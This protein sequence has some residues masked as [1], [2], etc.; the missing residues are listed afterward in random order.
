[1]Y[2]GPVRRRKICGTVACSPRVSAL[3]LTRLSPFNRI[4]HTHSI[5]SL[6][7]SPSLHEKLSLS[8]LYSSPDCQVTPYSVAFA[9]FALSASFVSI[10]EFVSS[11]AGWS[12]RWA[13]HLYSLPSLRRLQLIS[14]QCEHCLSRL[15]LTSP[16]FLL[17]LPNILG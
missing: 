8:R 6:D 10:P 4:N 9:T 1:M 14:P 17:L 2:N 15:R 16:L 5:M 11:L 3:Y 12:S 13:A 7:E